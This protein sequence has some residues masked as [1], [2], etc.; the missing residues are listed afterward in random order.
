MNSN[1]ILEEEYVL[2]VR[3]MTYNHEAFIEDALRGIDMQKTDFVFEVVVGDDFSK[4]GTLER[5]KK[6]SFSNPNLILKIL[7]RP[8]GDEYYK[9]RQEMGRLYN[10]VDIINNCSGKYIAL[11]DGDDYWT[12]PL[13]LQKQVDLIE[14]QERF[15]GCFHD[16]LILNENESKPV[17]KPWRKYEKEIFCLKDLISTISP[18]HT[19]SFVFRKESLCVP[20][21][22]F[23][24]QSGDMALFVL[25][26]LNGSF[27][28]IDEPMSVYRK[29]AN[30]V[31]N[32]IGINEY[33]INRIKLWNY[34]KEMCPM[35]F[36]PKV[37]KVIGFHE[38]QLR[39]TS[40][41][42]NKWYNFFQKLINK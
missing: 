6:F 5:I 26:G 7:N 17:L 37:E 4:D 24:V 29:N 32:F 33:H 36:R 8:I 42:S 12:D 34:F 9:K 25:I 28:R 19:S 16:T 41:N 21:W 3:L 20:N 18:F 11:L 30:G 38:N 2:S 39:I 27:Y 13:K 15:S 22:F 31:T 10:F 1:S 40:M 14:E 23:D 35:K